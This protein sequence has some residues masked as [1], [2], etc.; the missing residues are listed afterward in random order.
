[1]YNYKTMKRFF[2]LTF[3]AFVP[4]IAKAHVGYVID[5]KLG[6][7]RVRESV[8][9]LLEPLS[10]PKNL[11]LMVLTTIFVAILFVIYE[12]TQIFKKYLE[13]LKDN[14]QSYRDLYPWMLRLSL[15]IALLGAG[16]SQ[17]FV[18]PILG[19]SPFVSLI[20]TILGFLLLS[21]FLTGIATVG[22]IIIYGFAL[23][24]DLYILGNFDFLG[25]AVALLLFA[26]GRPGIDDIFGIPFL[27]NL[28]H[29]KSWAPVVVRFGIGF[30]MLYLAVYEKLLN[31]ELSSLVVE[32]FNMAEAIPVSPAMWVLSAGLVE[33]LVGL[34]LIIG[35][36][37]R[38]VSSIAFLVLTAS[39]FFFQEAVYSHIT[40]FGSLS[41]IFSSGGRKVRS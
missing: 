35:W 28:S 27:P 7:C 17:V 6:L 29:L 2:L 5:E 23:F 14:T 13:R 1:M 18:S 19:A 26:D 38:L 21:G 36:R 37:P 20:E 34:L 11:L 4:F 3:M 40:L 25:I 39:F 15:G 24:S 12:K 41:V 10:D 8:R 30:S 22:S 31:P 32:K 33:L 9:F 16:T